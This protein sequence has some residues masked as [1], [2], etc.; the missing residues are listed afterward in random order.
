MPSPP[1]HCLDCVKAKRSAIALAGP[2]LPAAWVL[3]FWAP[4]TASHSNTKLRAWT[5]AQFSY[6]RLRPV[7]KSCADVGEGRWLLHDPRQENR[8]EG[9]VLS[10]SHSLTSW[11]Y[12]VASTWLWNTTVYGCMLGK[13][14]WTC[15]PTRLQVH[16]QQ[17]CCLFV[18][19]A[20]SPRI[21]PGP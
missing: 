10:L 17:A 14:M 11:Q 19:I 2:V 4:L 6:P 16:L 7:L 9:P 3:S 13:Y 8:N 18:S 15:S 20:P 12:L 1:S 21:W 5:G